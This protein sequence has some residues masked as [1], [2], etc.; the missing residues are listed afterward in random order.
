MAIF[1]FKKLSGGNIFGSKNKLRNPQLHRSRIFWS[2]TSTDH[3]FC[4]CLC[5]CGCRFLPFKAV[6]GYRN[7][8]VDLHS[9]RRSV[10]GTRLCEVQR[11]DCRK[12][13]H[14]LGEIRIS[15]A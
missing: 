7:R 15:Y 9:V 4:L 11:N 1:Y 6:C 8:I 2:V 13:R 12:I 10:C 14:C 5:C 3:F